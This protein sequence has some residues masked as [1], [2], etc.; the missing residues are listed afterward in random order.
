MLSA[1]EA[2]ALVQLYVFEP[3][4]LLTF[5]F[6]ERLNPHVAVLDH[7]RMSYLDIKS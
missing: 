1:V 3:L 7:Q 6:H 4:W 2:H 5:R